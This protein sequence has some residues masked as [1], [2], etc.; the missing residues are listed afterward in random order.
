MPILLG[1]GCWPIGWNVG[2]VERPYP[3]LVEATMA[4]WVPEAGPFDVVDL[5]GMPLRERL[6][7][8]APLQMPES[9]ALILPAGE[10]WSAYLTNSLLGGD[11]TSWVM[12]LS[13]ELDC[14]GVRATCVPVGQYPSPTT[15]FRLEGPDGEGPLRHVRTVIAGIDDSGRWIFELQGDEQPFEETEAYAARLRRDRFTRPMLIRYLSAVGIPADDP[16]AYGRAGLLLEDPVTTDR[17]TMTVAQFRAAHA[18]PTA[19]AAG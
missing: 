6:S 1:G 4:S 16:H 3:E 17:R 18:S 10:R 2:F 7:R 13:R 5:V 19:R 12:T 11:P 8:L 9:R 14:R 15:V